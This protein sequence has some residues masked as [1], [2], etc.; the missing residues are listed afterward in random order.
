M[1]QMV[2]VFMTA[3]DQLIVIAA[4]MGKIV[5]DFGN[6]A[7]IVRMNP[8]ISAGAHHFKGSLTA[9]P[10]QMTEPVRHQEGDDLFILE[11]MNDE[12]NGHRFVGF[13]GFVGKL[14]HR[15]ILLF[16][17]SSCRLYSIIS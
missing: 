5:A 11:L 8:G 13:S 4:V 12:R 6:L 2:P 14:I 17:C 15:T 9:Q 7:R 3:A 10:G 1:E 16:G